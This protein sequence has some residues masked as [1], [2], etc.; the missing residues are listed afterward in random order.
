MS[1]SKLWLFNKGEVMAFLNSKGT[2][3]GFRELLMMT[4]IAVMTLEGHFFWR[5]A[6]RGSN[7]QFV[8]FNECRM[9]FTSAVVTGL[10]WSKVV[11]SKT[12]SFSSGAQTAG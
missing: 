3:E 12:T 6:G 4:V 9:L 1:G 5:A 11:P 7:L 10:N 8:E 2:S